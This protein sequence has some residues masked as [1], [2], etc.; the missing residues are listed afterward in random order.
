MISATSSAKEDKEKAIKILSLGI[1][2]TT[3]SI[4]ETILTREASLS[5]WPEAP[6]S[7]LF[8]SQVLFFAGPAAPLS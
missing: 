5:W 4:Q 6:G 7:G 3:Y 2:V 1:R 8:S